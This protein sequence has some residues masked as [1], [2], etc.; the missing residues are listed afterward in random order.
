[1]GIGMLAMALVLGVFLVVASPGVDDGSDEAIELPGPVETDDGWTLEAVGWTPE[2][3]ALT[4]DESTV[5]VTDTANGVVYVVAD[6]SADRPTIADGV[7]FGSLSQMDRAESAPDGSS[8]WA[9]EGSELVQLDAAGDVLDTIDLEHPGSVVAVTDDAVWLTVSGVPVADETGIV[10]PRGVVQRVDATTG[11]VLAVPVDDP[12]DFHLAVTDDAVWAT[13]RSALLELDPVTVEPIQEFPLGAPASALIVDGD[14]VL[15]VV[16]DAEAP[17]VVRIDGTTGEVADTVS[18]SAGA[19]GE[20]AI[21]GGDDGS[22]LWV[23]RPDDDRVDRIDLDDWAT[24]SI[25]ID[26]PRRIDATD[27]GVWLISGRAEGMLMVARR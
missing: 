25:D 23:L 4:A 15:V 19:V 11:E 27:D 3:T 6:P 17:S 12:T 21:V 7:A 13:V 24:T 26:E 9:A 18:L 16:A 2:A 5:R 22:E 8:S 1:V 20:A 14:E 10:A